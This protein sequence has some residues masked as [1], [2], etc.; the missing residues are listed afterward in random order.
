MDRFCHLEPSLGRTLRT[1]PLP[2]LLALSLS[3]S[4]VGVLVLCFGF[5][6]YVY[7]RAALVMQNNKFSIFPFRETDV[8]RYTS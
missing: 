3:H 4:S 6:V 2:L 5:A 8:K 7:V 1:L